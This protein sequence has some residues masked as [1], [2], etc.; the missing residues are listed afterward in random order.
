M[1]KGAQQAGIYFDI[2]T[3]KAVLK[4]QF[5]INTPDHA[6]SSLHLNK[7]NPSAVK[8]KYLELQRYRPFCCI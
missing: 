5:Y 8:K 7:L 6:I 4:M 2:A 1:L 3:Q